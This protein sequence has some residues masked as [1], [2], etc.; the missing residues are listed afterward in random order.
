MDLPKIRTVV[1]DPS[2]PE[3]DRL[4]LLRVSNEG[5]TAVIR[6]LLANDEDA[7]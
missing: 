2:D 3:G 5:T 6:P 1:P 4:V 7:S